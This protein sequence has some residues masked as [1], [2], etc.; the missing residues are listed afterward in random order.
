MDNNKLGNVL[1]E[2]L[3]APSM[4]KFEASAL[5]KIENEE[6]QKKTRLQMLQLYCA[7]VLYKTRNYLDVDAFNES[8]VASSLCHKCIIYY[9]EEILCNYSI[10]EYSKHFTIIYKRIKIYEKLIKYWYDDESLSIIIGELVLQNESDITEQRFN[11]N[12]VLKQ[13]MINTK[14]LI[15]ENL[16]PIILK[17]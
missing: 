2:S 6:N 4:D 11:D 8:Q 9:R 14:S 7:M 16:K 13:L 5:I 1:F 10:H 15:D 17:F 12:K 3:I